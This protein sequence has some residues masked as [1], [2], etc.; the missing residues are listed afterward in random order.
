MMFQYCRDKPGYIWFL[1]G[2]HEMPNVTFKVDM[3]RI[4]N[5]KTRC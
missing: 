4:T 1:P 5:F 3:G 2:L